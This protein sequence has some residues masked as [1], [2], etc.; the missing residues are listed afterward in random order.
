M[1]TGVFGWLISDATIEGGICLGAKWRVP[2][3]LAKGLSAIDQ[4]IFATRLLDQS[5]EMVYG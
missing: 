2:L 4:M 3:A 1:H 5:K